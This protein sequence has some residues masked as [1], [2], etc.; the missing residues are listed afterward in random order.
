MKKLLLLALGLTACVSQPNYGY[1]C[2][3]LL[4]DGQVAQL[5]TRLRATIM[6][7][8]RDLRAECPGGEGWAC[9]RF[10][11]DGTVTLYLWEG[12]VEMNRAIAHEQCHWHR[13]LNLGVPFESERSHQGW[14]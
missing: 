13:I 12:L 2:P 5:Q 10:H 3:H 6:L 8:N 1:T 7:P 4:T 14:L 11:A 9:S